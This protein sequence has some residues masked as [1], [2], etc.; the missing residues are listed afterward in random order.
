MADYLSTVHWGQIAIAT[1]GGLAPALFWLWFWLR[2]DSAHPEP[3]IYIIRAFALGGLAV[4][5]TYFIQRG[6]HHLNFFQLP[7][8]LLYTTLVWALVEESLKYAGV[9]L[10]ALKTDVFDEPVDAMVYLVSSALG[11]AAIENALFISSSFGTGGPLFL[12]GGYRFIGATLVHVVSSA[13]LGGFIALS[14]CRAR[15]RILYAAL[16]LILASG[17]HTLFNYFILEAGEQGIFTA[18]LLIWLATI[19]VIFFFERVKQVTCP[20]L[21]SP[22]HYV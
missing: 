5:P 1:L 22:S 21:P 2:E 18:C 4:L 8:N 12:L 10:A 15:R 3:K 11:F 6:L 20:A 19:F 13:I 9:W 14:F 16:G 7:E 17:L